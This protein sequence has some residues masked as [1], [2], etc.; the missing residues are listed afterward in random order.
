M[1]DLDKIMS[2][3]DIHRDAEQINDLIKQYD[4]FIIST[5]SKAKNE[6]VQVENDEAYSIGLLAFVEAIERYELNKGP[7]LPFCQ[8]VITSRVRT[9]M[10]KERKH[11]H[12]AFDDI[13][14]ES[15]EVGVVD[16]YQFEE[17]SNLR[18]EI[19]ALE[20]AL[21]AFNIKFSDLVKYAPKHVDTRKNTIDIAIK[22]Q[23]DP[24]M[25]AFLYEKK[26]LPITKMAERL[27]ASLKTIMTYK[28]FI[29]TVILIIDKNLKE[30]KS[31]IKIS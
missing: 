14:Y 21:K 22:T 8:L 23:E 5:V 29:I 26:R 13:D 16:Q 15:I 9:H 4:P 7:F 17:A 31:W 25:M 30:I 3:L 6:Y 1:V 24:M 28:H 20:S 27:K 2:E 10:Q 18:D 11:A 19:I 12:V